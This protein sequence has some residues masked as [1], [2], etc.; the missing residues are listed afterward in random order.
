M[1]KNMLV[2]HNASNT[3]YANYA[4]NI[5]SISSATG[6]VTLRFLGQGASAT[7]TSTDAVVLTVTAGKEEEMIE[8][9][10]S[11]AA[12]GRS[13]MTVI[14]DDERSKYIH[15]NITAVDSISVDT[16]A[17]LFKNVIDKAATANVLEITNA[18]SGSNV[19]LRNNGAGCEIRLP[20]APVDGFNFKL[21]AKQDMDSNNYDIKATSGGPT[22]FEGVVQEGD[23]A[24]TSETGTAQV[25]ITGANFEMG[26]YLEFVF[27]S[28]ANKY[29][30][31][32][33]CATASAVTAS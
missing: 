31:D 27:N 4:D 13:G 5:T 8:L 25:R 17:G 12:E 6:A 15:P 3:S 19:Y 28:T 10:A 20:L 9:V 18:D 26:D 33:M 2:F 22:A 29:F 11:A 16:G 7:A 30:F 23:A 24:P 14:A 21:I 1:G 32:G